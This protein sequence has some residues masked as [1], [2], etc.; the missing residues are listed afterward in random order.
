MSDSTSQV[1]EVLRLPAGHYC[2]VVATFHSYQAAD[3]LVR[4]WVD[5]RWSC[6]L[7]RRRGRR[8]ADHQCCFICCHFGGKT[9][10]CCSYLCRR[11]EACCGSQDEGDFYK[12]H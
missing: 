8:V 6:D 12:K 5:N 7:E 3:F 4:L 10:G 1:T 2:L 11:C 9:C